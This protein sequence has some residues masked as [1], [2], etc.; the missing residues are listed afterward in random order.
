M[1]ENND[2]VV[3]VTGSSSGIGFE[4]CLALGRKGFIIIATMR[5][6]QKSQKLENLAQMK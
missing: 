6:T 5:N 3:V 1:C 2:K 4:T